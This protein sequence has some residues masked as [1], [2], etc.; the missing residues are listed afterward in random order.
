MRIERVRLRYFIPLLAVLAAVGVKT[1]SAAQPTLVAQ[2]RAGA[3]RVDIT[4]APGELPAEF[5]SVHDRIHVRVLMLENGSARAI[6]AVAEVPM[7]QSNIHRDLVAR[8]SQ[9][10]GV[11]NEFILLANT[12]THNSLRVATTTVGEGGTT[13]VPAASNEAVNRTLQHVIP[14]ADRFNQSVIAATLSA[15]RQARA[16]LQPAR[17]GYVAGSVGLL[18][19]RDAWHP[20]QRRVIDGID[21]SGTRPIDTSLG[22]YKFESLSG[23][24]IALLLDYGMEPVVFIGNKQ[25]SGDVPG[26]ASRYIESQLG[27]KAVALFTIGAPESP[28]FRVDIGTGA[29]RGPEAAARIMDAMGLILGEE[30][31]ARAAE[32]SAPSSSLRISAASA[33]LQCSGKITAPRNLPTHCAYTAD[34]KLPACVFEDHPGPA[35]NLAMGLLRLGDVAYVHADANVVTA[36]TDKLLRASPLANTRVISANFG[37][38][39]FLVDDA[40]YALN[41]YPATDTRAV[42]GCGEQGFID[43][44]LRMIEQAP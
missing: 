36:V 42:P 31:I 12:H 18:A 32:I 24:P 44:A 29:G 14:I 16:A 22:V 15:A 2:L 20:T 6:V 7:I 40:A 25:I 3:A 26:A 35:V 33:A 1:A 19:S 21:R 30:A 34:S 41:T 23:E 8:L 39:R 11:A 43:N 28:R 10:F 27:G 17:A 5:T 4:P 9:E 13:P 37:Q 38:F